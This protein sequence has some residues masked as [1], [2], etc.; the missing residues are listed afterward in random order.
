[1]FVKNHQVG[2]SLPP[3]QH[4]V[5]WRGATTPVQ[6]VLAWHEKDMLVR[7]CGEAAKTNK[8]DVLVEVRNPSIWE[9]DSIL[10]L[11]QK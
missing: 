9:D 2:G 8:H 3:P 1:L 10:T 6:H 4:I 7:F 11:A 5:L